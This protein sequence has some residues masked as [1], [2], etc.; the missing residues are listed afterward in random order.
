MV[1][2]PHRTAPDRAR[3]L[4]ERA[5]AIVRESL[6]GR[7]ICDR[8]GATFATYAEKCEADLG[9]ECPGGRAIDV[10]THEAEKRVGL[11]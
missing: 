8:C 4:K 3:E 7:R 10:A 5:Q 1:L 11:R 2:V 6:R 9:S